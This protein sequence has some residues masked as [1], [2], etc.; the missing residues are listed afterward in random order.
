MEEE[1]KKQAEVDRR[2]AEKEELLGPAGGHEEGTQVG[3]GC[4]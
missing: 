1:E 3:H 4:G 2:K